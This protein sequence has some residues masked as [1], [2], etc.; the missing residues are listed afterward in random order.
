MVVR[1]FGT[2]RLVMNARLVVPGKL[3]GMGWY[4]YEI[5]RRLCAALPDVE[6]HW[7][8]DRQVDAS[9]VPEGV[10]PYVVGPPARH[11]VLW[12]V[13]HQFRVPGML[14]KLGAGVYLSPDGFIPLTTSVP[15]I[16][17]LHDIAFEREA[18]H[19]R[20]SA[21]RYYRWMFPKCARRATALV[22][23][24]EDARQDIVAAYGIP[25][26]HIDVVPNGVR[27]VFRL[28]TNQDRLMVRDRL[29][30]G[31]PYILFVGTVQPRKNLVRL[32]EAYSMAVEQHGID[33]DF[34]IVGGKGWRDESLR[35]ACLASTSSHRIRFV[36]YVTDDVMSDWYA[37]AEF[38]A[39]VPLFEGFGVP[40]IEAFASGIP[41]LSSNRPPMTSIGKDAVF[42]VDPESVSEIA[43]GITT[44]ARSESLR[45]S[46]AERGHREAR[47]YTWDASAA[48]MASIIRRL[49]PLS[50]A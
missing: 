35:D 29:N 48:A 22:T 6:H 2:M 25:T 45:R 36:G 9:L 18:T 5:G 15:T 1:N 49:A 31:R 38:L 27:D 11:P 16:A 39:F 33:L 40:I 13:W 34:V 43:E 10:R 47:L 26:E 41:V 4:S 20:M 42:Y 37:A 32:V 17:V 7:L 8:F 24:S 28:R 46:L 12:H 23:V 3:D 21:G 50:G 14:R 19:T 30:E 44:L